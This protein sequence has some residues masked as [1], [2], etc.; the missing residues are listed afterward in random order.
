MTLKR[1]PQFRKVFTVCLLG[2]SIAIFS[3]TNLATIDDTTWNLDF[4]TINYYFPSPPNQYRMVKYHMNNVFQQGVV[5]QLLDYGFG[6]IQTSVPYA[7]YL[8]DE[9]GWNKTIGGVF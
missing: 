8:Q 4:K 3:Q 1:R 7:N 2:C 6:G 5:D 9:N